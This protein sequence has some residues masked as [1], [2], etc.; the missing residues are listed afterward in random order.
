[1]LAQEQVDFGYKPTPLPLPISNG[2]DPLATALASSPHLRVVRA[3][4]PTLLNTFLLDVAKNPVLERIELLDGTDMPDAIPAVSSPTTMQIQKPYSACDGAAFKSSLDV[5][6]AAWE[7]FQAAAAELSAL[8]QS[9]FASQAVEHP[10]L[11]ELVRAGR[12][13]LILERSC[14]WR[15]WLDRVI[16]EEQR[17]LPVS[18]SSGGCGDYLDT[19]AGR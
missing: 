5:S 4:R 14:E 1:M 19:C 8:P 3:R 17:T 7:A 6:C 10:R 11:H 16:T 12:L 18:E 13:H 2:R 9:V 15:R